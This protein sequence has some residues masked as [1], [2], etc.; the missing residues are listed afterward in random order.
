MVF[1]HGTRIKRL[2]RECKAVG[3]PSTSLILGL[4]DIYHE[5]LSLPLSYSN[6]KLSLSLSLSLSLYPCQNFSV[7]FI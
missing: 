3:K 1:P 6:S 7:C 2:C 5:S 4:D